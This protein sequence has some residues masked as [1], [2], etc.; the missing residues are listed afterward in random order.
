ML[1]LKL[2]IKNVV[3]TSESNPMFLLRKRLAASTFRSE[4][5][6][7]RAVRTQ[8]E[9]S[10]LSFCRLG[11][12]ISHNTIL[13]LLPYLLLALHPSKT[14]GRLAAF[15]LSLQSVMTLKGVGAVLTFAAPSSSVPRNK[16]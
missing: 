13:C 7:I 9:L 10:A 2:K 15:S 12:Y 11:Q 14:E 4:M 3:L 1:K 6:F 5:I 8:A 16:G